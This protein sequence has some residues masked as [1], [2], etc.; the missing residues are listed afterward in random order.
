MASRHARLIQSEPLP[1]ACPIQDAGHDAVEAWGE[2]R[3]I[4]TQFCQAQA[5]KK[6]V[7]L[8]HQFGKAIKRFHDGLV[9]GDLP[10]RARLYSAIGPSGRDIVAMDAP[11]SLWSVWKAWDEA[12]GFKWRV[13]NSCTTPTDDFLRTHGHDVDLD[14]D[15][16][17]PPYWSEYVRLIAA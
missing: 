14:E 1:L 4:Q 9:I 8:A 12:W 5:P 10:M 17:D 15:V 13:Q 6:R 7:A 11:R 2:L 3:A 16:P